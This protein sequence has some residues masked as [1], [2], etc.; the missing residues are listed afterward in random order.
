MKPFSE[1]CEQNKLPILSVLQNVFSDVEDVLEIG[2]GTGQ[3]AIYFAQQLPHLRWQ[4]SDLSENITGIKLWL[5]DSQ[6]PNVFSPIE[7]DARRI[8]WPFT[9]PFDAVFSANTFHIM[10]WETVVATLEGVAGCLKQNGIF[11]VYGPFNYHQQYTSESNRRFDAWLKSRDRDSGI[12][13][14]GD[15]KAV[16]MRFGLALTSDIAMPANNRILVWSKTNNGIGA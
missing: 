13:D 15:L 11:V 16:A 5:A 2:S 4:T 10:N 14:V 7:L 6:L 9:M 8:P 1:S 3:H 12:R